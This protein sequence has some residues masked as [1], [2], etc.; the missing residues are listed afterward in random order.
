MAI[1]PEIFGILRPLGSM[2]TVDEL[3]GILRL[4]MASFSSPLCIRKNTD[5]EPLNRRKTLFFGCDQQGFSDK[6]RITR[7]ISLDLLCKHLA[8]FGKSGYG[9]STL[10]THLLMQLNGHGIPFLV[11]DLVV[12]LMIQIR[13]A[14]QHS[15]YAEGAG[16]MFLVMI[17][18]DT[19]NTTLAGLVSVAVYTAMKGDIPLESLAFLDWIP[20]FVALAINA[21]LPAAIMIFG[22]NGFA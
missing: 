11:I 5:P 12:T 8:I 15:R 1:E 9:K 21:L 4:P 19:A 14:W 7:G 10:V 13:A 16:W 6:A 2:A 22:M 20:A 3:A 18:Q 17:L